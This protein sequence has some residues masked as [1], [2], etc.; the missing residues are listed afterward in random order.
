MQEVKTKS[1]LK[2]RSSNFLYYGLLT[3]TVI[4]YSQIGSRF[5]VLSS[6]R[7]EFVVGSIL[8]FF[9]VLNLINGKIK[10][11]ENI[12]N[13]VA[14]LFLLVAFVT[15]PFALVK[16]RALDTFI[17]LFKFFS[18]YLMI[19]SAIDSEK[20][21]KGFIYVYLI[22][23]S[24]LFVQPFF[25]SLQGK[26]FIYNNHMWRLAGVTGLFAHPN[27]LGM[28]TSAN[29]PFFYYLIKQGNSKTLKVTFLILII[30]ALRVIMLTQSRAAFLGVIVFVFF[31]WLFSKKKIMGIMALVSFFL[32]LWQFTPQNT[33]DRF[34]TIR[35]STRIIAEG[36]EN[37]TDEQHVTLGSMASRW[38][39]MKRSFIAFKENPVTGLGLDCF[40]SFNGRRWGCWLPPHNTY[41]QALAETGILGFIAISLVIIFTL[42]NL[43]QSKEKLAEMK[44]Q[45]SFIVRL[46][47]A[48]TLYYLVSLVVS[49]FGIELYTNF[50]WVVGGLSVVIL[51]IIRD[52]NENHPLKL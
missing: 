52:Q 45:D 43:K 47:D 11:N 18:I 33:K 5:S 21:L 35:E 50:W 15:I 30:I 41:L 27:A 49:F 23:I 31:L 32:L 26:G 28:I 42:K 40:A 7:I 24:L 38:E 34:L 8:L 1:P 16:M 14:L 48:V 20:R 2:Y 10:F 17:K 6:F 13:V 3:Y 37:F 29:L 39:L 46:T 36:R 22:M 9:S 25:L 4:F 19:I 12:V 51:R 44:G